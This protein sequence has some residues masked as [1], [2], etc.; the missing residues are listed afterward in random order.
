MVAARQSVERWRFRP[1]RHARGRTPPDASSSPSISQAALIA[2]MRRAA[3]RPSTVS[4]PPARSG[5]NFCASRRYAAWITSGSASES[6]W[7]T[8]YASGG[9]F[10]RSPASLRQPRPA[11]TMVAAPGRRAVEPSRGHRRWLG[12]RLETAIEV[13]VD[14][15]AG[16]RDGQRQDR[17]EQAADRA[18]D[19]QREHHGARVQLD[20]LA[21][22]LGHE[23]V[24]LDLLD[25]HVQGEGRDDRLGAGGRREQHGRDC[26]DDRPDDRQQLEEAGDERQE[27]RE[28]AEDRIDDGAEQQQAAERREADREAEDHLRPDP[29]AEDALD[30][31]RQRPDVGAPL[32]GQGAIERRWSARAG[33]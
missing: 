14:V 6:T 3:S 17:A 25:E 24:V 15:P 23:H 10:I 33:P 19:D 11:G 13:A 2:T 21:L 12:I 29:L 26:R 27:Q 18:A 22:D 30:D 9:A 4:G 1:R 5:W 8:L 16:R 20:R 32:A 7:S 31:P 28:P